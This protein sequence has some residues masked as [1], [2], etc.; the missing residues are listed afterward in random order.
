M[1]VCGEA[2]VV[3]AEVQVVLIESMFPGSN[4]ALLPQVAGGERLHVLTH[5]TERRRTTN[6]AD[7][8]Q[9]VTRVNCVH[10]SQLKCAHTVCQRHHA[11]ALL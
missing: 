2:T 9:M 10:H 8:H 1:V 7:Y 3:E 5:S 6:V 4:D 11:E